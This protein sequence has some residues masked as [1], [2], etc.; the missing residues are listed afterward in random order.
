VRNTALGIIFGL[1][2]LS[3]VAIVIEEA[4]LGGRRR[5]QQEKRRLQ[6]RDDARHADR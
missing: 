4:F 2:M 1:F 3:F 6:G 5:R